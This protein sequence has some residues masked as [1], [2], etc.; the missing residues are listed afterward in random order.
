M[1]TQGGNKRCGG[2]GDILSGTLAVCHL[3]NEDYGAVLASRIVR[4]AT[5]IAQ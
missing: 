1:R 3:W 5:A 2:L 4:I